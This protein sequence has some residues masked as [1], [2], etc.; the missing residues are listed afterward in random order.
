MRWV[1]A[2]L[3]FSLAAMQLE[4]WLGDDR[5]A[6]VRR[7]EQNVAEQSAINQALIQENADLAAEIRGLREGGE[8]TEERARSELGLVYPDESFFQINEIES[9]QRQD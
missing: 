4:L 9:G 6:A 2:F 1:I 7:H 8:A 3:V 5:L